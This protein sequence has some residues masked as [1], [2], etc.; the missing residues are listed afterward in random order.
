MKK[1]F[2][3]NFITIFFLI[4]IIELFFKF[5]LNTVLQGVDSG[6]LQ[7]SNSDI[8]PSF[9]YSHIKN[10]KVFGVKV[11]TDSNGF[12]ITEGEVNEEEKKK[13]YFIGGSTT[14]GNG[15]EEKNTFVGILKKKITNYNVINASVL[16]SDLK[17]NLLIVKNKIDTNNLKKIYINFALDD[18][19]ILDTQNQ[20]NTNKNNDQ[21]FFNKLKKFQLIQKINVM[22]RSKSATY[23]WIKG[24]F[25]NSI[26]Q[27]YLNSLNLYTDTVYLEYF[28]YYLEE[29]NKLDTQLKKKITFLII[30]FNQQTKEANCANEDLAEDL[31]KKKIRNKNFNIIS[32]REKFCSE[33]KNNFFIPQDYCH[34]SKLG[35]KF[36]SDILLRNFLLNEEN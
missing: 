24:V 21:I 13:V 14:F 33:R 2:L 9:N 29:F 20:F 32:L 3:Y 26:E 31:I 36:V 23:V 1:I 11:F 25:G 28:D 22:L 19:L 7:Q 30:P 8:V 16:G 18:I 15:V 6:I 35:H 4:A 12:R 27:N 5:Y 34:L 17:N 10:K